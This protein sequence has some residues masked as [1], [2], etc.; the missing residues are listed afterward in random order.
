M[1][2]IR[3]LGFTASGMPLCTKHN[4]FVW[5]LFLA[6]F[7]FSNGACSKFRV[8]YIVACSRMRGNMVS[9]VFLKTEHLLFCFSWWHFRKWCF[10]LAECRNIQ[11]TGIFAELY[12]W[13]IWFRCNS[14][15]RESLFSV[16]LSVKKSRPKL[17]KILAPD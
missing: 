1:I 14:A 12:Y 11:N 6:I 4:N 3:F 9:K 8:T 15:C 7:D 13:R 5:P 10:T 16:T 2:F 17:T